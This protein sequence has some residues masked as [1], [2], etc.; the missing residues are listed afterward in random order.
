MRLLLSAVCC[1]WF[2]PVVCSCCVFCVGVVSFCFCFCF[3][4]V[5]S[6]LF[7]SCVA[8][9][10]VECCLLI[11]VCCLLFVVRLFVVR[12]ALPG[13]RCL[14]FVV[15]CALSVAGCLVFGVFCVCVVCCLVFGG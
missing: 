8:A 12:W 1:Q 6:L 9:L 2:V 10:T 5:P 15:C 14:L 7:L 11:V 3:G 4:V 13:F